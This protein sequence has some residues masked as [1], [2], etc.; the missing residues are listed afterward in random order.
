MSIETLVQDIQKSRGRYDLF[1]PAP[2]SAEAV[3]RVAQDFEHEFEHP[4]PDAY[5]TLLRH[6]DGL[7]EDG[8]TIWPCSPHWK[9]SESVVSANRELRENVSEDYLYFGMRDDSA[10]VMELSTGRFLA[11]ELN[12]L[13][14][15]EDFKN[16]E[17][18]I[19][20]MLKRALD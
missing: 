19:E 13:A 5:Q 16:A 10:F 8:L 15:W 14:E 9:F 12:G 20:F 6:T 1:N 18:M 17:A 7:M 3:A 2:A 4:L 11:V